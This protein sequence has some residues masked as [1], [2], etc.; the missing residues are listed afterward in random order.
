MKNRAICLFAVLMVLIM[1]VAPVLPSAAEEMAV[2]FGMEFDRLA[3]K[4]AY[5]LEN[6]GEYEIRLSVPG[7][8][9]KGKYNEIIVMVDASTSQSGN[10]GNLKNTLNSL[11]ESVLMDDPDM[12]L[13]LMGFG[14]GPRI[15]GTFYRA[16]DVAEFL[17]TATQ[18]DF[19]QERSATNCEVGFQFVDEYLDNSPNLK[20]SIVIYT[21][22]G[23]TN[24]AEVEMDWSQW[25]DTT[26]FDYFRSYTWKDVVNYAVGAE[27]EH[28]YAG[29]APLSSTAEAYPRACTQ[30]MMARQKYGP[31]SEEYRAAADALFEE[32]MADG[33]AFVSTQLKHIHLASGLTWGK[34]YSASEIEKAF[35]T[36]FRNYPGAEDPAYDSYMDLFF[37]LL[38]DNGG[39]MPH[40]TRAVA[41]SANLMQNEK[42]VRLYHV[43]YSGAG[44][45]W[46]N[47]EKGSFA[48]YDISKLSY[49]YS[50]KF[51]GVQL[52]LE[53]L[54][55]EFIATAYKDTTVTDPMSKWVTMDPQTIRIY[56][57][58]K[59]VV[60]WEYG[61]G[62]LTDLQL[63]AAEPIG[64][65]ENEY[66]RTVITWKVKDGLLL[67]SDRYSLRYTVNVDETAEGFVPGESYPANDPTSVTW[68]DPQDNPVTEP[69]PVPDV[70]EGGEVV[71]YAGSYGIVIHKRE[72]QTMKP[73]ADIEFEI[74]RVDL[75]GDEVRDLKPTPEE[76]AKYAVPERLVT[77]LTTDSF[78]YA[79]ASLE[80]GVYM[81]V[82]RP[83]I[84][85]EAPVEPFYV[86]LPMY[87]YQVDAWQDIVE[88][89]PKNVLIDESKL[90]GTFTVFKH[91]AKDETKGLPDARFQ[92][93]RVAEDGENGQAF[94]YNGQEIL[95]VPVL[96]ENQQ[97]ILLT[98][99]ADGYLTSPELP[100]GVYFLVEIQAP[101]GYYRTEDVTMVYAAL[102]GS[103]EP[104]KI[105]NEGGVLLPSTGGAGTTF[106]YVLGSLMIGGA[107]IFLITNRRMR[108]K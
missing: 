42:L 59:G 14:I 73:I 36:Y 84:R 58:S 23:G 79:E 76:I 96:D 97:N 64:L 29:N 1:L 55:D 3:Q 67:H 9:D 33:V 46:M 10:F 82:E 15:A 66:G 26:V 6:P 98:T 89:Y 45:T 80:K 68:L 50:T 7:D 20:K 24:L 19:L 65:S 51:A 49:V 44:N 57:D 102:G 104:V 47:P 103:A 75:N 22:D 94:T 90:P 12:R 85:V 40:A 87:N 101:D 43:G 71:P 74:Y 35:Q 78:G 77:V 38:G 31:E 86:M 21:S 32:I 11:A 41:A 92:L 34:S 62:W 99:G 63:T 2:P 72:A 48:D 13:T 61:K 52:E 16:S 93:L 70:Q 30:M 56:D 108:A 28:I 39:K 60:L 81:L 95:L 100:I 4:E 25:S 54:T 106:M 27:M 17:K 53:K 5:Q 8:F 37:L 105:A 18:D 88:V 107:A 69:I 91:D 83:D